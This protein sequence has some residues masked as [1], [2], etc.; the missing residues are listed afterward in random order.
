MEQVT[1]GELKGRR[2]ALL[3]NRKITYRNQGGQ[4]W[5]MY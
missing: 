3:S 5:D 1:L 4:A 2:F